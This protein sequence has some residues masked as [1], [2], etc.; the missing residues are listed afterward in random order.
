MAGDIFAKERAIVTLTSTG[1]SITTL[2]AGAANGTANVD[3]RSGGNFA[4]DFQISF[5]LIVQWATI[6][7]IVANSQV[8]DLYLIPV[9]DGTNAPDIDTTSGSSALPLPSYVGSFI[10]TKAPT[11]NTNARFVSGQI[12]IM[13]LLYQPYII[14]RSGQTMTANWTLKAVS[15]RGQ[16]T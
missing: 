3:G 15:A 5:E 13:P 7:G 9:T 10:A 4:D 2:S 1:S 16:Y 12:N 11:A 8:A 14:N 6:T